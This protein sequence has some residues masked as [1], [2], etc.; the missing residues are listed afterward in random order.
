[1][2]RSF[3]HYA[4]GGNTEKARKALILSQET[5]SPPSFSVAAVISVLKTEQGGVFPVLV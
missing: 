2:I 4:I 1:V 5:C 3:A